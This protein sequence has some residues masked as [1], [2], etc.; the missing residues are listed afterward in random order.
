MRITQEAVDASPTDE[1]DK[2]VSVVTRD[3]GLRM[4]AFIALFSSV[5]EWDDQKQIPESRL[6]STICNL[7]QIHTK[8]RLMTCCCFWMYSAVVL[9]SAGRS[10]SA[11]PNATGAGRKLLLSLRDY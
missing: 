7:F 10:S 5:K 2:N 9:E 11:T 6:V 4:K 8:S 1:V 3:I